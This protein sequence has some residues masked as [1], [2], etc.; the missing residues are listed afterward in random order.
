MFGSARVKC[1]HYSLCIPNL[2]A[3]QSVEW[4]EEPVRGR[5]IFLIHCVKE[6]SQ[7]HRN[8]GLPQAPY[9][10]GVTRGSAGSSDTHTTFLFYPEAT[11]RKWGAFQN[12]EPH[13]FGVLNHLCCRPV[14]MS[15][16]VQLVVVRHNFILETWVILLI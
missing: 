15:Q 6:E 5:P 16:I 8:T 1:V 9:A 2:A 11:E 4:A 14:T 13:V 10:S 7:S 12:L 3:L